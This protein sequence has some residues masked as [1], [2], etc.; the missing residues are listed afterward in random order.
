MIMLEPSLNIMNG[1]TIKI[2]HESSSQFCFDNKNKLE[3][4]ITT[5]GANVLHNGVF[6]L[7]LFI[8]LTVRLFRILQIDFFLLILYSEK[9]MFNLRVSLSTK[10]S[11]LIELL[12]HY[13]I[14]RINVSPRRSI[15]ESNI[16]CWT[17]SYWRIGSILLLQHAI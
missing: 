14:V 2:Q 4:C 1:E 3:F 5:K 7:S 13:K 15:Y 17:K 10:Y 9:K 11:N 16:I 6:I 12:P 8:C